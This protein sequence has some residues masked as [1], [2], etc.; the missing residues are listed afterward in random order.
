MAM[1]RL[2]L[3]GATLLAV[4]GCG[5]S[6]GAGA[7]VSVSVITSPTSSASAGAV[8]VDEKAD[9]TTVQATVGATVRVQLHSSYWS[10]VG[11]SA[12][13]LLA[14]DGSSASPS[15]SCRPGGG[16]AT[17][18]STFTA[19]QPGTVQ[20]TADRTSCGE[21]MPC[22]PDQQHFAVTVEITG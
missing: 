18:T 19:R 13:Q 2:L 5:S 1:Q 22:S 10:A 17:V 11:S 14:P 7:G 6:T 8:T 4:A 16:C 21:A 3:V 12:P 15:P 20:L 9:R